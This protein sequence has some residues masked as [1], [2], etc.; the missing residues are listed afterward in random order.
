MGWVQ[1]REETFNDAVKHLSR[2]LELSP[3]DLNMLNL[4]ARA[5]KELGQM[6]NAYNDATAILAKNKNH[7]M[8]RV[9]AADYLRMN[10][11]LE[12]AMAEYETAARNIETKAYA[13][14]Y[15]EVIKQKLE[16]E[17]IEREY[18]ERLKNQAN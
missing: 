14:H 9:I 8:A 18:Q 7:A 2:A 3:G 11:K 6:E 5:F 13:E 10:G 12:D 16:E 1:V 17:E 15:I 4:R